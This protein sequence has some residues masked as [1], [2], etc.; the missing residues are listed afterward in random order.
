MPRAIFE[1][2]K[3]GVAG[4]TVLRRK[5][6]HFAIA[7]AEQAVI[8]S[9]KPEASIGVFMNCPDL[10]LR[11]FRCH[12]IVDECA[13]VQMAQA[14]VGADPQ[15]SLAVLEQYACAEIRKPILHLIADDAMGS[16]CDKNVID[17]LVGGDPHA[18]SAVLCHGANEVVG[19]SF[20]R[21][22]ARGASPCDAEHSAS[23]GSHPH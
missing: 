5:V 17:A 21:G 7:K 12:C 23:V 19:H 3:D 9:A 20:A 6:A 1:D 16:G 22:E 11:Q 4:E 15:V 13:P 10:H 14:A 2:L 8:A 18:A